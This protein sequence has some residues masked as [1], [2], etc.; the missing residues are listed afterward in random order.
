M[1]L[2]VGYRLCVCYTNGP[3]DNNTEDVDNSEDISSGSSI[4]FV[5]VWIHV[6]VSVWWIVN[7]GVSTLVTFA[8]YLGVLLISV[9]VEVS[10][11]WITFYRLKCLMIFFAN[12]R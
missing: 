12:H 1:C 9:V 6:L 3:V 2:G 7:V 4:S 8:I 5:R 10:S 11:G